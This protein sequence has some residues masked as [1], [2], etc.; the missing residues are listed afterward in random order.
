MVWL[1]NDDTVPLYWDDESSSF[2][3]PSSYIWTL[4]E[5]EIL[6]DQQEDDDN[7][8][9][10]ALES[11]MNA[12]GRSSTHPFRDLRSASHARHRSRLHKKPP[13]C[14]SIGCRKWSQSEH[15]LENKRHKREI[16][17]HEIRY[18]RHH[19]C[20]LLDER[21][22]FDAT[23]GRRDDLYLYIGY[24]KHAD[25]FESK[26]TY[27]EPGE[28]FAEWAQRR[29]AEMRAVKENR[30]L[31]GES[32]VQPSAAACTRKMVSMSA[33][34]YE[35]FRG[36]SHTTTLPTNDY[37][38]HGHAFL[39]AVLTASES[40][41]RRAKC[42]PR[43][44]VFPVIDGYAWFGEYTRQWHRD[45]FG[46][47]EIEQWGECR[48]AGRSRMYGECYCSEFDKDEPTPDDERDCSLLEWVDGQGRAL[49]AMQAL[50]SGA[51]TSQ[52]RWASGEDASS[53][54]GS[55]WSIMNRESEVETSQQ[56]RP[57]E[58]NKS[59]VCGSEWSIVTSDSDIF[60]SLS[61]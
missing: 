10:H 13:R 9:D 4:S 36:T 53:V 21:D 1:Y 22:K 8:T 60:M 57:S 37:D 28:L 33:S 7:A 17:R 35:T 16:V 46:Y 18:N 24:R 3:Y 19:P 47:W 29:I 39:H 32:V 27:T 38:A 2:I 52:Q 45:A 25:F 48:P 12:A 61:V 20:G 56:R 49:M 51:E 30:L 40:V 14:H 23:E 44:S 54:C 6:A 26:E 11:H 31:A 41:Q 43:V 55:E 58:E 5:S 34:T 59:S 50:E 42:D 15:R